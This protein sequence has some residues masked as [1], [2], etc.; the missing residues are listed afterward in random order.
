MTDQLARVWQ[1]IEKTGVGMLTTRAA[2]GLRARPMEA[3][4]DRDN[5][6]IWFLTDVRS[7][8][9]D[10]ID[11][12]HDVG[13]VFVDQESRAYLSITGRA[14]VVQ[15][16]AIAK[17][18]WRKTD[19]VWWPGGPADPNVRVVRV[20]PLVAELWDGPASSAVAAFEFAMARLTGAK[21]HLGENRKQTMKMARPRR[22][23]GARRP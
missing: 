14:F 3:R 5:N 7:A 10:E 19:E 11:T 15:D 9:D 23:R 20:E 1:L 16:S 2:A 13:L 12:A 18:I 22:G 4:S 21:P 8:K 6:L 17:Q